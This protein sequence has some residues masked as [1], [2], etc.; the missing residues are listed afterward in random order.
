MH[1][2]VVYIIG[3]Y[4]SKPLKTNLWG[5]KKKILILGVLGWIM[6]DWQHVNNSLDV[7]CFRFKDSFTDQKVTKKIKVSSSIWNIQ[8]LF[9]AIDN[10]NS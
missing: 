8:C 3:G 5:M 4:I 9:S 10:I 6:F 1:S 2:T 7:A